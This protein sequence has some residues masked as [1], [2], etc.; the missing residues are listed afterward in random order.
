MLVR[1][2]TWRVLP[3]LCR[4]FLEIGIEERIAIHR[5]RWQSIACVVI[6]HKGKEGVSVLISGVV[7]CSDIVQIPPVVETITSDT[8]SEVVSSPKPPMW[9]RDGRRHHTLVVQVVVSNYSQTQKWRDRH[10]CLVTSCLIF[11]KVSVARF[12]HAFSPASSE[13]TGTAGISAYKK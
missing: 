2:V 11:R 6:K 1:Y 12:S 3:I 9:N 10:L 13:R 5:R 8:F 4:V 7:I